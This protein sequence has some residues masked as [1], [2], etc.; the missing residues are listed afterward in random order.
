MLVSPLLVSNH[1]DLNLVDYFGPLAYYPSKFAV[2][3][4]EK[5]I[6]HPISAPPTLKNVP[7]HPKTDLISMAS[8]SEYQF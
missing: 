3:S 8:T 6:L 2:T 5:E 1:L 7:I 4:L